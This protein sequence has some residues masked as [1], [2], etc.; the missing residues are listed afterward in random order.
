VLVFLERSNLLGRWRA[1]ARSGEP[2]SFLTNILGGPPALRELMIRETRRMK[3]VIRYNY[4]IHQEKA[5]QE[6]KEGSE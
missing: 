5:L 4:Q 1:V 6:I 3:L 2:G